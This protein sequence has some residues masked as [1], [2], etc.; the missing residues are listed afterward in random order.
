MKM[1]DMVGVIID[2]SSPQVFKFLEQFKSI[3]RKLDSMD[4]DYQ[5]EFD[6]FLIDKNINNTYTMVRQLIG[7]KTVKNLDLL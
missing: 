4:G 5:S 2:T 7:V 6:L 3:D 1:P